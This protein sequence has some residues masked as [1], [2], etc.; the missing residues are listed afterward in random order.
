MHKV[1]F[2]FAVLLI[3]SACTPSSSTKNNPQDTRPVLRVGTHL[4]SPPMT[5]LQAK[6][7]SG[8]EIDFAHELAGRLNL[9]LEIIEV[10]FVKLID[11]LLE[12]K[13][14]IIMSNMS[15]TRGRAT[16]IA[17]CNSYY[18]TG[19]IALIR[20]VDSNLYHNQI[21]ISMSKAKVGVTKGTTGDMM[22]AT[23]FNR[24]KVT[25]YTYPLEGVKDLLSSRIDVFIH[26]YSV[27]SWYA[28]V[29]ESRGLAPVPMV[30]T[31]ENLAWAV[32]R[33]DPLLQKANILLDEM[34]TDGTYDRIIMSWLPRQ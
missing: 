27:I 14:D 7:P 26:D 33:G 23:N 4:E 18:E 6:K 29:Y 21:A 15:M 28:S 2:L 16:R 20:R 32:R 5:F 10:P 3:V 8:I 12:G 11:E 1:S 13:I 24:A 31:R 19:Q 22:V 30:Y 25:K 9:R 34:K 17:F